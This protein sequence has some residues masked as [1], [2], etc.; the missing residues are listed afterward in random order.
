M[1]DNN[2]SHM[3][4]RGVITSMI[5]NFEIRDVLWTFAEIHCK[6]SHT[7][8]RHIYALQFDK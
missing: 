5:L 4:I 1:A 3:S 6:H 2:S 8:T 7:Y